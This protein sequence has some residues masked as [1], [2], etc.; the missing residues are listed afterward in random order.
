MNKSK[1]G[2]C[3]GSCVYRVQRYS[4][5]NERASTLSNSS[6]NFLFVQCNWKNLCMRQSCGSCGSHE[7][8]GWIVDDKWSIL[9][10]IYRCSGSKFLVCLRHCNTYQF[11]LVWNINFVFISM[12]IYGIYGL[13]YKMRVYFVLSSQ[14]CWCLCIYYFIFLRVM[15]HN[16][17]LQITEWLNICVCLVPC[18]Q[19]T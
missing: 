8:H 1:F 16:L 13:N 5:I 11:F 9:F 4:K 17:A 6:F 14:L 2:V 12:Q 3:K 10:K 15:T 7:N 18:A 19:W